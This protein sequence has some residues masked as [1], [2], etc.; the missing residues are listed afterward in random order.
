MQSSAA[1]W[2]ALRGVIEDLH[3]PIGR[4]PGDPA[5]SSPCLGYSHGISVRRVMR[6]GSDRSLCLRPGF[7][8]FYVLSR[9]THGA[10]PYDKF[11]R[12]RATCPAPCT[13]W[14]PN[15][16]DKLKMARRSRVSS[17]HDPVSGASAPRIRNRS[18]QG[19]LRVAARVFLLTQQRW[20]PGTTRTAN[21]MFMSVQD[22][23]L[24][25]RIGWIISRFLDRSESL[26]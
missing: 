18:P 4:A 5:D 25:S 13:H 22:Q 8:P 23:S 6:V 17:P 19:A 2:P 11:A 26:R 3:L 12:A 10:P 7:L 9:R 16:T 24:P 15:V 21:H 14:L 20:D 1:L